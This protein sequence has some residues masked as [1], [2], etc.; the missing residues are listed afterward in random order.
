MGISE[1]RHHAICERRHD[2]DESG[3][4]GN[5]RAGDLAD[6]TSYFRNDLVFVANPNFDKNPHGFLLRVTP[7]WDPAVITVARRPRRK[8]PCFSLPMDR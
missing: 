5:V 6:R 8:L 3:G 4:N 7:D 1:V 2:R